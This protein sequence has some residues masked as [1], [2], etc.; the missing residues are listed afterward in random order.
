[1]DDSFTLIIKNEGWLYIKN[2]LRIDNAN[3]K[4]IKIK[5]LFNNERVT[6]YKMDARYTCN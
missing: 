4:Y 2:Y 3:F 5:Y 6:Y 1:M